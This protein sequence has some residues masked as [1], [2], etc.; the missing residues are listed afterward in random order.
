MCTVS[1]GDRRVSASFVGIPI[2]L[3]YPDSAQDKHGESC[4][5]AASDLS[6]Q[7]VETD[8]GPAIRRSERSLGFVVITHAA[9]VDATFGGAA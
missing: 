4:K 8:A 3:F 1:I 6:V 9:P 7:D 2:T 5:T